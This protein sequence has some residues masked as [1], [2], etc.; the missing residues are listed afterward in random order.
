MTITIDTDSLTAF[1]GYAESAGV[2]LIVE[3]P[4]PCKVA[5][6]EGTFMVNLKRVKVW[7]PIDTDKPI[8]K[9]NGH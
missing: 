4:E 7:V 5:C 6:T 1:P 8:V 2:M 9:V 3:I